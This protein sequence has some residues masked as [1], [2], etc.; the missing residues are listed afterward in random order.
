MIAAL[1]LNAE[2]PLLLPLGLI[3]TLL[4]ILIVATWR[5][6]NFVRDL[7]DAVS[8]AWTFRDQ[9]RWALSLERENRARKI[10]LYV[11]DVVR[12]SEEDEAREA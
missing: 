12:A 3:C 5:L 9:E 8:K 10:P 6:A 1:V 11:P 7:R 2:T 4:S